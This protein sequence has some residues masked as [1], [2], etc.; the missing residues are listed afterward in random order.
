M[1]NF[2]TILITKC[3]VFV[4]INAQLSLNDGCQVARSGANGICRHYEDCP[5]VLNELLDHGL[6]PTKCGFQKRKEIICCP[7]P[8]TQKP[9]ISTQKPN[10]MSEKSKQNYK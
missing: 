4:I 5:V 7:L 3:A 10:R 1:R 2:V 9:T 6:T 8:P